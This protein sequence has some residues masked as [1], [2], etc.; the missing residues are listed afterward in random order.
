MPGLAVYVNS[1]HPKLD[2]IEDTSRVMSS[3]AL[4]L[5][6]IGL[7]V[8]E[9]LLELALSARNARRVF[10]EGG[11]EIGQRH[12]RV[13]TVLHTA[14]LVACVAEVLLLER[15]FPGALG[16]A[17]F[18]TALLAQGLRYWAILTLGY[19]WN[20]RIIFLP[21]AAPVTSGPYRFMR[22][23]NYLAVILELAA[24]PLIHGAYLTSITFSL[25]N[26]LM[27]V[28]RIRAEE[29]ALGTE[30]ARAFSNRRRFF[31]GRH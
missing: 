4:Y 7:L 15:R 6:F 23:P 24:V 17:A 21:G 30:Y 10:A 31:P 12:F 2:R 26:A 20:T 25:A 16:W 1:F 14:F 19:R 27:L 9:R 28:V 11:H 29:A 5:T 13:M 3:V 22:H 18:G 8:V